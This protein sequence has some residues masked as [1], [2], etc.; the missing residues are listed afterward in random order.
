MGHAEDRVR[1]RRLGSLLILLTIALPGSLSDVAAMQDEGSLR[2]LFEAVQS[3]VAVIATAEQSFSAGPG[4]VAV[5]TEAGGLGSGVLVSGDG[6]LLT[7]AHV[8]Q[9]AEKI[10][11]LFEGED[12]PIPARVLSSEPAADIA[13]LQLE[14]LPAEARIAEIGDSDRMRPG[15]DVF[16]VGAP[17]GLSHTLTVGHVSGRH[18]GETL[19]GGI[20]F[21][22][23]LQ[24]DAAINTGNSGGP[25]FNLA[26]EVVG[27]VS[28]IL[29]HSGG[30]EG[31]GFAVT[32][33]TA[34]RLLLESA[35][36]W[37]GMEGML[38]DGEIARILNVPPPGIAMLVQRVAKNSPSAK[39]GLRSGDRI[40][41]I[42]GR[43]I[44]LGGDLI[45]EAMGVVLTNR[46][47]YQEIRARL[48]ALEA[49]DEILVK[50]LR[51]GDVV[52]LRQTFEG[53]R[54]IV[55]RPRAKVLNTGE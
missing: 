31:L 55:V 7:A 41:T 18:R 23:Y 4:G 51:R 22:E 44:V 24:T 28:H 3:S 42:D 47:S 33:N 16:V 13:L 38:V 21:G 11:V 43:E 26:G 9:T 30:Y 27:I 8:V 5:P 17:Y 2:H 15:D 6:K 52:E 1:I 53:R 34:R 19:Y 46:E 10:V 49:G 35:G 14:H 50:V 20:A 36:A 39:L 45:L 54:P 48:I 12:A 25:M 40:A 32:S 29:S 37:S